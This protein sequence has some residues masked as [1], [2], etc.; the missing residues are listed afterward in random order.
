MLRQQ[1][2]DIRLYSRTKF[3]T[4]GKCQNRGIGVPPNLECVKY[5]KFSYEASIVFPDSPPP[6]S[7]FDSKRRYIQP[8]RLS[9]NVNSEMISEKT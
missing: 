5:I 1:N 2:Y 6:L 9:K 3:K 7:V 4:L 8:Y